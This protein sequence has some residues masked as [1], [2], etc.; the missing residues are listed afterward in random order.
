MKTI[1]RLFDIL[2]FQQTH[3]PQDVAL[4][5][6]Q[7]GDWRTFSSAEFV[8]TVD[9]VSAGLLRL[10]IDTGDR[11]A[12]M[13][14]NRPEWNFIDLG[15]QQIGAIPVPIFPSANAETCAHILRD[16]GSKLAFVEHADN[17]ERIEAVRGDLQHIYS[18]E[19]ITGVR[20]WTAIL[21]GE[22]VS[23]IEEHKRAIQED[24]LATIIYTSGTTGNPKG[25]MLS[26]KNVLSNIKASTELV[27]LDEHHIALS[28]LP[29]SHVFERM[30]VYLYMTLGLSI[31]YAESPDTFADDIRDVRPH[32]VTVVPR[33]LE[34]V[35]ER[36]VSRALEQPLPLRWLF[37]WAQNLADDYDLEG[38]T[39][40]Y[41][42]QLAI[43]DRFVFR[44]W[45]EA[46]GGNLIAIITGGAP[47]NPRLGRI[48]TAAGLPVLE[49]YGLTEA[50]PVLT[51]NHLD[52]EYRRIGSVGQP[53]AG[54]DIRLAEDG[55]ILAKGPNVMLGYHNLPKATDEVYRDGWLHTGDV[56]EMDED[57]FLFVTDRQGNI[58]KTSG[59][60]FVVPQRVEE[61]FKQS[62][63]ID[64]IL[65]LGENRK[66]VTAI[67]SPDFENL[68]L[69][70]ADHGITWQDDRSALLRDDEI[71]ARYD[72]IVQQ[73]NQRL[74]AVERIKHYKLVPDS[75]TVDGDEL[76]PTMKLKRANL[77]QRYAEVI[78][79]MYRKEESA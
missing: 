33:L 24:D 61:Q 8:E 32:V 36:I 52:P 68:K 62:F 75:W 60:K 6:K 43:A 74:D 28:L 21:D 29:L 4:A 34:K 59:G 10:G 54:V 11:I 73:R 65:V 16:S 55:E 47:L 7:E 19:K 31:Y 46:F 45:R 39:L 77:Q 15:A 37:F 5:V 44:R 58:F 63:L 22:D 20:H 57:G 72:Q 14:H 69:W 12:L 67:I 9:Q 13:S 23:D 25:V 35:H 64:Q 51:V 48:F 3:Y 42:L 70:C 41:R 38:D 1:R 49:G 50:A 79:Q 18:F 2:T 26:H 71:R 66:M 56:G 40:F 76:T 30:V 17:Y 53:L 78:E 27:P